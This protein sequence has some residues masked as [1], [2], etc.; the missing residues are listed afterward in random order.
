MT[1]LV[2]QGVS[3]KFADDTKEGVVADTPVDC[4]AIQR[5]FN[6]LEKWAIRNFMKFNRGKYK[7]LYPG[8][9]SS[10]DIYKCWGPLIRKA[11]W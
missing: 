8:R 5:D 7:L 2:E 6:K 11:A 1:W 10:M 9:Y 4:V 3:S